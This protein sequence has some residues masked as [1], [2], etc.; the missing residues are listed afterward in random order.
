MPLCPGDGV[1][2]RDRVLTAYNKHLSENGNDAASFMAR[3][4]S[5]EQKRAYAQQLDTYMQ[6]VVSARRVKHLELV[7]R[8]D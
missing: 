5:P 1:S 3:Y 4:K 7:L 8:F 6:T 2:L